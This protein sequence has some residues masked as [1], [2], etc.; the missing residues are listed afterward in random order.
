VPFV[1]AAALV[2]TILVGLYLLVAV[3]YAVPMTAGLVDSDAK[4]E[5]DRADR[6]LVTSYSN[7]LTSRQA[8]RSALLEYLKTY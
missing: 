6:S 5:F 7:G 1:R 2:L 4:V 3:L 8:D